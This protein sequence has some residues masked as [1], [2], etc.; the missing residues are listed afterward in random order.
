MKKFL[1]F[2]A[3]NFATLAVMA[4]QRTIRGKVT[5]PAGQQVINGTVKLKGGNI[6]SIVNKDGSY[7]IRIPNKP[8][9]LQATAD[10]YKSIEVKLAPGKDTLI[11]FVL[12][13]ARLVVREIQED[14]SMAI[15]AAPGV[16][17]AKMYV[18]GIA[19]APMGEYN[20]E[21]YSPI[22][23]NIFHQVKSQP[24]STFSADVDRASYSNIRRFLN[25]GQLPPK[26]AVRVEEMINYFDYQYNVPKNNDPV[27]IYTDMA[28]CPWNQEHQLVRIGIQ[29]KKIAAQH[30]P[31]S[32]I[33]FLIDVS[34]SMWSANKLPLVK[35]AFKAL[36]GQLRETD[37]V[38]IVVYAGAAGL[39]LPSTSG[40]NKTAI[41]DA[42]DKL[43]AGGSTAGGA[44][45]QLAYKVAAE[46]FIKK[47]NNRVILATDG[48]FNVG[49]SSD[50]EMQRLI[51][52]H[53]NKGVFLSVLGFGMGNYK[54]NKLELL[55]DKGNGNYAYIDNFEEARRTFVTEFGGTLFTIAKDVKLQVE[56]N[57]KYVQSY[58]L[59]GYENRLL[60]NE[61]FNNDKKD[62]GDMGSGHTVT[63]LYEIIPAGKAMAPETDALKYQQYILNAGS[64]EVLTVKV[65]YKNPDSDKSQLLSQVL[66]P[67]SR[68]IESSPADFRMAAA[69]AEFGL[70]LRDSEFKAKASYQHVIALASGAKGEDKEGYRSEFIQMVKKAGMLKPDVARAD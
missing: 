4:Q 6:T 48:D 70:L 55:A 67:S 7:V 56:F 33:V 30:L 63:A 64:G 2:L 25:Q 39:V 21:N 3:F 50:G 62:A 32:N 18:R 53:R 24:L 45:I 23:E 54:D 37:K 57:P 58:R 52:S 46:N 31:P 11:N 17:N 9:T 8:E 1:W 14:K 27:A 42:L 36:A 59:I 66:A 44:G 20:T 29:G 60:Q 15:N 51:E 38:S 49:A 26:D 22:N 47:G 41:L 68:K 12:P 43:E 19:G 5:G 13:A 16:A 61:D 40:D 69:V 28:I 35:Q 34:G 10:G 65:R